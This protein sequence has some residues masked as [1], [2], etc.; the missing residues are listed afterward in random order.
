MHC[1]PAGWHGLTGVQAGLLTP[2]SEVCRLVASEVCRLSVCG[3]HHAVG[4]HHG[5]AMLRHFSHVC[6]VVQLVHKALHHCSSGLCRLQSGSSAGMGDCCAML[7]REREKQRNEEGPHVR[8]SEQ[9]MLHLVPG[10]W[11]VGGLFEPVCLHR[12]L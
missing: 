12:T 3:S 5:L 1:P 2:A 9:A 11:R 10:L 6:C 4:A 7:Q 8:H